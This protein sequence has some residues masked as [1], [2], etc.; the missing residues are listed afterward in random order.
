VIKISRDHLA[1]KL[2]AALFFIW[3]ANYLWATTEMWWLAR[4]SDVIWSILVALFFLKVASYRSVVIKTVPLFLFFLCLICS[5]YI[6][7]ADH[8]YKTSLY[9]KTVFYVLVS[10]SSGCLL[11]Q[12]LSS[13]EKRARIFMRYISWSFALLII[14]YTIY[15]FTLG[16]NIVGSMLATEIGQYYQGISRLIATALIVVVS[17]KR[18]LPWPVLLLCII[19]GSLLIISFSGG[20][21]LIGVGLAAFLLFY[22][23]MRGQNKISIKGLVGSVFIVSILV[24]ALV[25]LDVGEVLSAYQERIFDK[26]NIDFSEYQSRPWLMAQGV[27]LW[28]EGPANLLV[29]MGIL[30]YSLA[31]DY[32]AE[33]RH[34]H[35]LIIL[36]LVWFGMFSIP[37]IVAIISCAKRALGLLKSRSVLQNCASILFFLY[38]ALSMIGGDIEQNRHLFFMCGF[39]FSLSMSV[40]KDWH[41]SKSLKVVENS[42]RPRPSLG[43][44][45]L[46]NV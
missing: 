37:I 32:W 19:L 14:A 5:H 44:E 6:F 3:T 9:S 1:A 20:G 23:S 17:G 28:L 29:G 31:V 33:Y 18:Y 27:K 26:M 22:S 45:K 35:N 34:P 38:L 8:P 43:I 46:S 10:V 15:S 7:D 41:F 21:A 2:F 12:M 30:N 11:G 40:K 39:V 42:V 16:W 4:V 36:L 25:V 13:N 24:L